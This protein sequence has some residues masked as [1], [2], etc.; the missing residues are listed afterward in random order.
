MKAANLNHIGVA[1]HSIA[2]SLPVIAS[3]A[4]QSSGQGSLAGLLRR[5]APRNDGAGFWRVSGLPRRYAPR[6]DGGVIA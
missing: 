1:T 2:D 6:N 3:E 4:R 5:Y